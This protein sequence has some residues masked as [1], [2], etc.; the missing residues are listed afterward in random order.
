MFDYLFENVTWLG[1]IIFLTILE[2]L[3]HT[4]KAFTKKKD[5]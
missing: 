3:D 4:V 1:L 5:K 2:V